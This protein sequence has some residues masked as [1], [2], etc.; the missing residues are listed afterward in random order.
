[1]ALAI[2]ERSTGDLAFERSQ[3]RI[4]SHYP[5]TRKRASPR[6]AFGTARQLPPVLEE[7]DLSRFSSAIFSLHPTACFLSTNSL[8]C[9]RIPLLMLDSVGSNRNKSRFKRFCLSWAAKRRQDQKAAE[10]IRGSRDSP[11]AGST[12]QHWRRPPAANGGSGCLLP[13]STRNHSGRHQRARLRVRMWRAQSPGCRRWA[14]HGGRQNHKL[15]VRVSR[16]TS[17]ERCCHANQV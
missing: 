7:F 9:L 10:K 4:P 11:E 2:L 1:M 3:A 14:R 12:H 5:Q 16:L 15:Q 13:A 8:D 6:C 17:P